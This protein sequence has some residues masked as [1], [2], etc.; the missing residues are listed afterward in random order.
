MSNNAKYLPGFKKMLDKYNVNLR[1]NLYKPVNKD[2][3]TPSYDQFWSTIK[4]ISKKFKIV[5]CSEPILA[6]VWDDMSGGSKCGN[7]LR[8]HPDGEIFSC[9]YVRN[10]DNHKKFNHDKKNLPTFCKKCVVAKKCMGGCYGRRVTENRKN[11]P[12]SFCPF[13]HGEKRPAI[14]FKKSKDAK[15]LIHSNYLCTIIIK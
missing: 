1:I 4:E 6:L 13:F 11:L 14:K 10:E 9:V 7:S 8:I 15:N 5:S 2:Q 3:F 12:D